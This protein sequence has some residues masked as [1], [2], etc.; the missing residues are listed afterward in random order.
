[1]TKKGRWLQGI[2]FLAA[3]VAGSHGAIAQL[4]QKPIAFPTNSKYAASGRT[5]DANDTIQLPFWDDFS[6]YTG[7]PSSEWWVSSNDVWVNATLG[8]HPPTLGVAT[9]DGLN[10]NGIPHN[11][12]SNFVGPADS[13]TSKAID[14]S[15]IP[16][17]LRS[18]VYLSFFW[19]IKG[20]GE[21]PNTEDSLRLQFLSRDSVWVTKWVLKG[22]EENLKDDFT[23]QFVPILQPEF[24]HEGFRFRFQSFNKQTGPFDHWHLD[25]IYLNQNRSPSNNT[26]FDR[27]LSA[28]PLSPLKGIYALPPSQFQSAA[29]MLSGTSSF[30]FF[31]LDAL[32]QPVEYNIQIVEASTGQL[33]SSVDKN[34]V[35]DPIPQGL[36]RRTITSSPVDTEA[37]KAFLQDKDSVVLNMDLFLKTGDKYLISRVDPLT[38][39]TTYFE[40]INYRNNDTTSISLSFSD[41]TAW[42]D[43]TAEYAAGINQSRGQLAY[44]VA[45][46]SQDTL[47]GI[48]IHFPRIAP[49]ADGQPLDI[50]AWKTL[51][52]INPT[53]LALQRV[54]VEFRE[55]LDQFV[56]Y[57]FEI[58]V[59][60]SDTFYIGYRQYT[61]NFVG[62]GLDKNNNTGDRIYFN[63]G[64]GWVQNER[65]DGSLMIRPVF[66]NV[67]F[68]SVTGLD[69]NPI[70]ELTIYPNPS[71]GIVYFS[72]KP[73]AV[74]IADVS[75]KAFPVQLTENQRPWSIDLTH[76]PKGLYF[77]QY[78]FQNRKSTFKLILT[79]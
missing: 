30:E 12:T 50:I 19:Q 69:E 53:L 8:L 32:L 47:T 16:A 14:L 67:P 71:E 65:T 35:V 60:V 70:E 64:N 26:Y 56:R 66:E 49:F 34:Q 3:F 6:S 61:D 13:L 38:A 52:N 59:A 77:V 57:K 41:Y 28:A 10:S 72:E 42:D 25:Y 73:E 44:K 79:N 76:L 68:R 74:F 51:T 18:T 17:N 20:L 40:N 22:G 4:I 46:L 11:P 27:A 33:I 24:Y 36:E 45:A 43:G 1:M 75:G 55:E 78:I 2:L 39:D 7:Q 15:V 29:D 23:Q 63:V 37:I 21:I 54:S 9:F 5:L 62:I 58:P 31:N 48:D